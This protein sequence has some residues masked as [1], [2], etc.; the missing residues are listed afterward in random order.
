MRLICLKNE[1]LDNIFDSIKNLHDLQYELIDLSKAFDFTG[2]Q[3]MAKHLR[4]IATDIQVNADCIR[5]AVGKKIN[6]QFKQSE[7]NT[8]E[9]IN[10]VFDHMFKI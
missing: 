8:I 3:K 1:Y 7:K 6:D 2:N 9:T 5:S 10:L 4:D